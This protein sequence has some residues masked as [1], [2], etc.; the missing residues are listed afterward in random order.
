[1]K[2]TIVT[3]RREG[4]NR[5]YGAVYHG[6]TDV[7]TALGLFLDEFPQYK[8]SEWMLSTKVYK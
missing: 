2:Y 5:E 8:G 6:V 7:R 3:A 1:M 4:D